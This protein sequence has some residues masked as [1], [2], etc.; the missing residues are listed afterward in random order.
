ME[1]EKIKE[2]PLDEVSSFDFIA[3]KFWQRAMNRKF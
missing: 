3:P 1:N 2:I